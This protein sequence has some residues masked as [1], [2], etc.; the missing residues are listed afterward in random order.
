MTAGAAEAEPAGFES[1]VTVGSTTQTTS[2]Q[3]LMIT[4]RG[5]WTQSIP[6]ELPVPVRAPGAI[7]LE[8]ACADDGADHLLRL[9]SGCLRCL[10]G[11]GRRIGDRNEANAHHPEPVLL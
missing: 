5:E 3:T 10:H 7:L 4:N 9:K 1:S 11:S 8:R 2:Q 6:L